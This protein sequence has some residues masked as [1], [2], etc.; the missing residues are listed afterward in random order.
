MNPFLVQGCDTPTTP[1]AP[2]V[3]GGMDDYVDV[4]RSERAFRDFQDDFGDGEKVLR[5]GRLVVVRGPSGCGKTALIN[6]CVHW[7][8]SRPE[9]G[10]YQHVFRKRPYSDNDHTV[11]QRQTAVAKQLV[12][13][14]R[15]SGVLRPDSLIHET[16]GEPDRLYPMLDDALRAR[17]FVTMV[18]PPSDD[19]IKELL[20][21]AGMIG[22]KMLVFME[23]SAIAELDDRVGEFRSGALFLDVGPLGENDGDKFVEERFKSFA[24]SGSWPLGAA[25]P[26][27]KADLL[28]TLIASSPTSIRR[29]QVMLHGI[30]ED[31]LANGS[32]PATVTQDEVAVY[33]FRRRGSEAGDR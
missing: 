7:L 21:Y 14:L 11:A 17:S 31:I 5:D 20:Y 19:L 8:E 2:P 30:Y 23:T 24:R 28:R 10:W 4:D 26:P 29:L 27:V 1:L 15:M 25:P 13:R 3:R 18:L 22:P 9:P 33:L 32:P 16:Q 6:R 12:D